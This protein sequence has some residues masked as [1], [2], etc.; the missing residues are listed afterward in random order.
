MQEL[1]S[2]D[3]AVSGEA[4]VIRA[5]DKLQAQHATLRATVQ[6]TR[7]ATGKVETWELT[8]TPEQPKEI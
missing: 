1:K 5:A 8:A 7:A 2:E 4:S 6:V 3:A